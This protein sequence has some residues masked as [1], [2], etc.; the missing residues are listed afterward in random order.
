MISFIKFSDG[1]F[2]VERGTSSPN[3]PFKD[4]EQT[5]VMLQENTRRDT[6]LLRQLTGHSDCG[7]RPEISRAKGLIWQGALPNL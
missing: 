3:N 1:S 5:S 6:G 4:R 7:A 2:K